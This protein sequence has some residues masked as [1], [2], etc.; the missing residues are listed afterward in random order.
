MST[1]FSGSLM[2]SLGFHFF[3]ALIFLVSVSSAV[4]SI[5]PS[6]STSLEEHKQIVNA[7]AISQTELD[8]E[9]QTL[10]AQDNAAKALAAKQARDLATAKANALAAIQEAKTKQAALATEQAAATQKAAAQLADL[11]AAQKAAAAQLAQTKAQAAA[12][13]L[14]AQKQAAQKQAQALAAQQAAAKQAL[15]AQQ[16][17]ANNL[18][19]QTEVNRYAALM[20]QAIE[21]QWTQLPGVDQQRLATVMRVHLASDGTVLS[22]QNVGSS[23]N[24][25]LDRL[26]LSAVYKASPLPVPSDPQALALM[27]D[28]QF[29]F[30]DPG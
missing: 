1:R 16:A 12:T 5:Q 30:K 29:N 15:M 3:L 4:M 21:A 26:A 22:A 13:A 24:P 7:V 6:Q 19:M 14:A 20:K 27:K 2:A 9:V 11:Q 23:G 17:A 10:Q 18:Q 25:A 28:I 8:H